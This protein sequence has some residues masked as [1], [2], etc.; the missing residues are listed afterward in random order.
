MKLIFKNICFLLL[1]VISYNSFGQNNNLDRVAATKKVRLLDSTQF[2]YIVNE[3]GANFLTFLCND[4]MKD[5]SGFLMITYD[6]A[7]KKDVNVKDIPYVPE[8]HYLFWDKENHSWITKE[9]SLNDVLTIIS[10][11]K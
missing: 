1:L 2:V 6:E 5:F 4:D 7:I 10:G 11:I 9:G 8:G 3:K